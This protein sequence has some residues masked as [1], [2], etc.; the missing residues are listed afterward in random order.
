LSAVCATEEA[1]AEA[2]K[3]QQRSEQLKTLV[4]EATELVGRARKA[5]AVADRGGMQRACAD[6]AGAGRAGRRHGGGEC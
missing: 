3:R 5:A 6:D 4:A 1:L 2:E